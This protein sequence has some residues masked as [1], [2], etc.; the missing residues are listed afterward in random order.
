LTYRR[1]KGASN[2][3]FESNI[4]DLAGIKRQN[5]D[6]QDMGSAAARMSVNSWSP[7]MAAAE[8]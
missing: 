4:P 5:E 1:K 6:G 7:T 8:G 3:R 2:Q